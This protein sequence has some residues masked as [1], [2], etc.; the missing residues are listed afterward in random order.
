ML[1][2]K[3]T[4]QD[5]IARHPGANPMHQD[6]PTITFAS[7]N[8]AAPCWRALVERLI[9]IRRRPGEGYSAAAGGPRPHRLR[10]TGTG[11][12]AAFA[13]PILQRLAARPQPFAAPTSG[14]PDSYS[15]AGTAAQIGE[16]IAFYGRHL[17]LR[18]TVH[19]WRRRRDPAKSVP[20]PPGVEIVVAT[21]RAPA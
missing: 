8:L 12:T 15:D 6:S 2:P 10:S 21:P 18:H 13:L 14:A 16:N 19:L 20:W 17:S 1:V 3:R 7:L 9:L 4:E 5:P 11:K